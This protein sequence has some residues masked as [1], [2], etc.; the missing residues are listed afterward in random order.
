MPV[1]KLEE[2]IHDFAIPRLQSEDPPEPC[3]SAADSKRA[4][5]LDTTRRPRQIDALKQP[6]AKESPVRV[7]GGF[8]PEVSQPP[9]PVPDPDNFL[10]DEDGTPGLHDQF[11]S[12]TGRGVN[13]SHPP[14]ITD[15]GAIADSDEE[16]I[17]IPE[18]SDEKEEAVFTKVMA[19]INPKCQ[20][21]YKKKHYKREDMPLQSIDRYTSGIPTLFVEAGEDLDL[22]FTTTRKFMSQWFGGAEQG[23]SP[24]I[25]EDKWKKMCEEGFREGKLTFLNLDYNPFVPQMPGRPGIFFQNGFAEELKWDEEEAEEEE[26]RGKQG[27]TQLGTKEAMKS[28]DVAPKGVKDKALNPD[29]PDNDSDD[30]KD[31][32]ISRLFACLGVKQWLYV[33]QYRG[34]YKGALSKR[35]WN[36][37]LT[38]RV[39]S[40]WVEGALTKG[41]GLWTR[42]RV[43]LRNRPGHGRHFTEAEYIYLMHELKDRKKAEDLGRKVTREQIRESFDQGEEVIAVNTMECVGYDSRFQRTIQ[44]G[45]RTGWEQR[46]EARWPKK[47]KGAKRGNKR[48]R[49]TKEG[50][51][52]GPPPKKRRTSKPTPASGA[53]S[54][55]E[56]E[57]YEEPKPASEVEEVEEVEPR[58]FT[59]STRS[60]MAARQA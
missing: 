10:I 5:F 36:I 58:Y 13:G 19:S 24:P 31:D 21:K 46:A 55:S 18:W 56:D 41:W 17:Q 12:T 37:E 45:F 54:E 57:D 3:R 32:G 59:R 60:R 29:A 40:T 30:D 14:A 33:G 43:F 50:Q 35:E 47:V 16:E 44:D 7:D 20:P 26:K 23:V 4:T 22:N 25:A 6:P 49:K 8:L 34:S 28:E 2:Y 53:P 42:A 51:K 39:K 11:V 52:K 1:P 15:S 9:L 48:N 27:N 38:E